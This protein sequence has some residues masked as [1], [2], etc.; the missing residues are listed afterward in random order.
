M[1]EFAGNGS[2]TVAVM[3]LSPAGTRRVRWDFLVLPALLTLMRS[4]RVLA[5]SM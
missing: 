2:T 1:L 4:A 5:V 3:A